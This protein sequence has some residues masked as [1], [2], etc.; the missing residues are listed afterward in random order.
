MEGANSVELGNTNNAVY[1]GQNSQA[2]VYAQ[3]FKTG[4]GIFYETS[5]NAERATWSW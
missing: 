3:E 1:A 2:I 5:L 4:N